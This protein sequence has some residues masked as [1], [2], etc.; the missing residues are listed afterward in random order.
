MLRVSFMVARVGQRETRLQQMLDWGLELGLN[1][2][3][4]DAYQMLYDYAR[5]MFLAADS[6]AKDYADLVLRTLRA[7]VRGSFES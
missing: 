3:S 7:R 5:D 6:T 2:D 1:P 4:H